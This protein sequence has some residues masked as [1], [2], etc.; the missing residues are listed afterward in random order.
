MCLERRTEHLHGR[1]VVEHNVS[2]RIAGGKKRL[3]WRERQA[4]HLTR[5][6][7]AKSMEKLVG[8]DVPQTDGTVRVTGRKQ[9]ST[10][11]QSKLHNVRFVSGNCPGGLAGGNIPDPQA[12]PITL[13]EIPTGTADDQRS[14][15]WRKSK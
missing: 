11:R 10:R 4:D 12:A 6:L 2:A 1:C 8:L 13:E 3:G 15:V 5:E 14:S 9:G 7:A